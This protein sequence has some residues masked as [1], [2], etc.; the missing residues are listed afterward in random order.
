[1]L[2]P[3]Q[4]V[5]GFLLQ[6]RAPSTSHFCLLS[7]NFYIEFK[8]RFDEFVVLDV[9]VVEFCVLMSSVVDLFSSRSSG[10]GF[11]DG[12]VMSSLS[13]EVVSLIL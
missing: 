11:V 6:V 2:R 4:S 12:T 8:V 3:S 13:G 5:L 10:A 7:R 1:M 9:S